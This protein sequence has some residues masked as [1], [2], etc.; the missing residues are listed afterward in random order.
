MQ[1][2]NQDILQISGWQD[3]QRKESR[4]LEE[5]IQ[6]AVAAGSRRL[7]IQ[8]AGQHGIGGRLWAA[9]QEKVEITVSGPPGQ[10][11]GSMGFANTRIQVQGNASDD[12]GWLN[13]GADIVVLGHAGNGVANAMAQ[14]RVS[15][16]GN[17]GSRAMT[18]TKRNPRFAPP[19][20]WVLGSVG[21]YFA[22]FMA[23]GTAVVCGHEPQNAENI[24]GYRSCVGMV[25][26]KIYFR[27]QAQGFSQ[28]DAQ[29][30]ALTDQDWQW[31][32][33]NLQAFLQRIQR[34]DLWEELSRAGDWQ[35]LQVKSPMQK[36]GSPRQG[37]AD[38]R[39]KT[40]EAELGQGGLIGDLAKY[41]R[42]QIPVVASGQLR[43]F[44]PVWEQGTY[45]PPCEAA[46][47]TGIPVRDRWRLVRE[48]RLQEAVNLALEHTPFPASVCGYLCPNLCMQ[49]CSRQEKNLPAVDV[50]LLGRAS[51]EAE[52]PA[53]PELSGSKVAVIGAGP[54]GLSVAWQLRQKGHQAVVFDRSRNIGG[55]LKQIIPGS[56]IPEEVLDQELHRL[57]ELL[58][59]VELEQDLSQEDMEGLKQEYDFV[60]LAVGAQKPRMLNIPGVERAKSALEFLR[61]SKQDQA[62]V[63]SRVVIIGAGNV[64]CDVATEA[65]RLGAKEITLLDVQEPASFGKERQA[66][67]A[68]GAKFRWPVFTREITEQG[69]VLDS[70]ELIA[71]DTVLISVGEV[72][73][74]SFLPSSIKQN[75]GFIEVDENFQATDPQVFAIGDAV[76]PGLLTEAIGAGCRVAKVLD[77]I[78]RGE[79][80]RGDKKVAV[81]R[82]RI[83]LEYFDPRQ[84]DLE[85]LEGCGQAC[86]SCGSC[87]ECGICL[88]I[89]PTG[90]IFKQETSQEGFELKADPE[91]CIGCGFCASACPC[92]I[93]EMQ[94]NEVLF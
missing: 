25:G 40:W 59:K 36:K 85:S 90:A 2:L 54:A 4:V 38:F 91:K 45:A 87:R 55:K 18:M 19:E 50:T 6:E 13:A 93:W 86:A 11:L 7:Q 92:G 23:G 15:I 10:R 82:H 89:C 32:Q 75:R 3:G 68:V 73:E 63:G 35:L 72:P 88:A 60:I 70:G 69:V 8:A 44:V 16:G 20:L 57:Q 62:K 22:E 61:R 56:R 65:A 1:D 43:R 84:A 37:M 5:E 24:L 78:L 67:E 42:S 74:L 27:G 28:A 39:Q 14:G 21:D 81:D 17:T 94:D 46:C 34:M 58:P 49:A 79:R 29:L 64:G 41:D 80:P 33:E 30:E 77:Q 26:G 47:P 52:A 9:A 83:R 31:L 71:A 53:L 12:V 76:Q 66:A 51:L 48:N